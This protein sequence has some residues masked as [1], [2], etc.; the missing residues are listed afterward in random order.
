MCAN[1]V[2]GDDVRKMVREGTKKRMSFA[3]CLDAQ[4]D[5][6]LM[7]QPGQKPETLKTPLKNQGGKP[8]LLWGT[9]VVRQDEM[10]M[11]CEQAP[12][13]MIT[14]LK[15]FLRQNRPKVNVLFRDDGGN[16]LDS[17]K[18]EQPA[19][20]SQSADAA[21]IAA[22]AIDPK[23]LA[24]LKRRLKRIQPRIVL[25]EGPLELKL[26]RA[27]AK[28]VQQINA[29]RLQEAE[30][31]VVVIERAVARIGK[32]RETE[33]RTLK[34]G[35]REMDQRSL[36]AQVKRAQALRANVARAP[37][38]ARDRLDRAVQVA[39]RML[40]KRDLASAQN[41]MDRIEKAL[42]TLV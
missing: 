2:L 1:R 14:A 38:P 33:E 23:A 28:A 10:E 16:L 22:P 35:Q 8:P 19:K 41:V 4:K 36:G 11:T 21:D 13:K 37:G 34:R 31:L 3:F 12:A 42:T 6:V 39:A 15:R 32:D 9:Y 7:I 24:P 30:T 40:K 25:A 20:T 5:P 26:K 18:P 17:L 27:F 29:G